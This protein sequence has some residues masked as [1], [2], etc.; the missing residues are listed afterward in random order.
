MNMDENG[1]DVQ[2]LLDT[3]EQVAGL[4]DL[5][6]ILEVLEAAACR[7]FQGP[8]RLHL[9]SNPAWIP[10]LAAGRTEVVAYLETVRPISSPTD[11]LF[12][13]MA[14]W[15]V[16]RSQLVR[17]SREQEEIVQSL[18]V[19][20]HILEESLPESK[21]NWRDWEISGM[22]RPALHLGGDL[23]SYSGRPERLRFL[24]ADAVGHGLDSAL[25]VSECRALWR[26][27]TYEQDFQAE[28]SRLS[29]LLYE[30]TG[31]E[32]YV[33]AILGRCGEDGWV[34]FVAC[35]QGP[36][37]VLRQGEVE[38]LGDPDLPLGLFPDQQFELRKV[39]LQPG[40][41]LFCT[42]DG[43]L[44]WQNAD[45]EMF[46]STGVVQAVLNQPLGCSQ[47]IIETVLQAVD[48]FHTPESARDDACAIALI[49]KIR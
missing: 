42:T 25:L 14:G 2:F 15:A 29:Q 34:E 48:A 39:Q 21:L 30:N 12:C 13:R 38:L 26:G 27:L 3:W 5:D 35:G 6:A 19:A 16:A 43:M 4:E 37:F 7:Q 10:I 1:A 32:R 44:E 45:G 46:G 41:A 20:R 23:F 8:S 36:L 28:V 17:A 11:Q 47:H 31:P 49:R 40:Q 9:E 22:L 18:R 24:L 33:A